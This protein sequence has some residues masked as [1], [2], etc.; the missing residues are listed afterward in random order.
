MSRTKF[1]APEQDPEVENRQLR[2]QLRAIA[3]EAHHNETVLRRFHAREL[4]LLAAESL[5]QLLSILTDGMRQSFDLPAIT[6]ALHDPNHELRHLLHHSGK[7]PES[8]RDIWFLDQLEDLQP[9][10]TRLGKPRLGPFRPHDHAVLF[11]GL[12]RLQS[13]ALLPMIRRNTLVGSIHLGSHDSNRFTRHHATDFLH[14]LATISAICLENA[15]NREHLIISGLTDALTGLHN[16]RYLERRLSEEV[17][18]AR[19]YDH[20]LSCLFID[21]DH[22]KK[23]NDRYGHGSGDAVLREIALRI[24]EC[25]RAS[26]VATRFG[27]EEFALLLPQTDLQEAMNLAERVRHAISRLCINTGE[28][29]EICVTVSIGVSQLEHQQG[30]SD[31]LC[32]RNLLEQADRALYLAKKNGR[33]RV[34]H[35]SKE[36]LFSH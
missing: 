29:R 16:R 8:Y 33:N 4:S 13:V 34:E 30:E 25:L 31:K 36:A 11:P 17:A 6:L 27:G 12:K 28:E 23:I 24:R 2:H 21:V 26:D 3:E 15:I 22:F 35:A 1:L 10:L 5:P 14:R 9:A 20:P 19:R 7:T 18:R 32:G